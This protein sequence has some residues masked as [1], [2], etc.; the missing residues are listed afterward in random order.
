M[1]KKHIYIGGSKGGARDAC[2]SSGSKFFQFHVVFGKIWQNCM[3]APPWT[4]DT[5][6]RG[7]PGSATDTFPIS[8][9]GNVSDVCEIYHAEL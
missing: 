5:P 7:N 6:P 3:L 8:L 1:Q 4:V 2:P 9:I